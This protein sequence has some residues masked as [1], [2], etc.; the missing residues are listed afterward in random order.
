MKINKN[1]VEHCLL[2]VNVPGLLSGITNELKSHCCRCSKTISKD[3]KL[4]SKHWSFNSKCNS[5]FKRNLPGEPSVD[6]FFISSRLIASYNA[7][8]SKKVEVSFTK[9]LLLLFP[10]VFHVAKHADRN[11]HGKPS[12]RGRVDIYDMTFLYIFRIL[13]GKPSTRGDHLGLFISQGNKK[14][15]FS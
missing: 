11:L 7:I 13:R 2:I 5:N 12:S 1:K 9:S 4:S 10:K 15:A 8:N 6:H 14:T 3:H